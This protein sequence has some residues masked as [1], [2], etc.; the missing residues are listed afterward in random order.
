MLDSITIEP[1]G[2]AQ[3]CVIWLHGLGDSGAGFAPIVPELKLPKQHGIRFIFPHAPIR[4]V[5]VNQGQTMRAWYD[6]K[7]MDLNNRADETGVLES[8]VLVSELIEQQVAQG[9]KPENIVIAGFSQ[10]GVIALHLA[11]RS[12]HHFAG[13]MALSSYMCKPEKLGK[14]KTSTNQDTPF[15]MHHGEFDEVV[16]LQAAKQ[17]KQ[18]LSEHGFSV[19]WQTYRMGHSLCAQQLADIS[20]WLRQRLGSAI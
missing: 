10:G 1:T 18:T 6:I 8:M 7:T 15:L 14:E 9:I 2:E 19:K 5:T 17:A 12:Q 11:C 16:P 4:A 3:A 13:V 20:Y